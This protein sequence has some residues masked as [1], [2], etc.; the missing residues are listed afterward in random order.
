MKRTHR[1]T[2]THTHTLNI[3]A[4]KERTGTHAG[5]QAHSDTDVVLDEGFGVVVAV[6]TSR[7]LH[8]LHRLANRRVH[9]I[10]GT[11]CT[12]HNRRQSKVCHV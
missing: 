7:L 3:T 8:S 6:S 9:T 1:H 10:L 5:T 2:K 12:L 4:W 11:H